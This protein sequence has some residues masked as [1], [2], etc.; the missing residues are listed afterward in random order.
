[1]FQQGGSLK[2]TDNV[3]LTP[4]NEQHNLETVMEL[5]NIY[6]NVYLLIPTRLE[7]YYDEGSSYRIGSTHITI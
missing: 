5:S 3:L 1:M 7:D 2:L 6:N 4:K